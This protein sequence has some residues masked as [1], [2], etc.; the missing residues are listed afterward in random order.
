MAMDID[1]CT[2]IHSTVK[3]AMDYIKYTIAIIILAI[4]QQ[5]PTE[6]AECYNEY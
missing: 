1:P 2:S 3:Y 4:Y 6:S 5:K